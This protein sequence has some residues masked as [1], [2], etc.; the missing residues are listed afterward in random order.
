MTSVKL[1]K[2]AARFTHVLADKLHK[3]FGEKRAAFLWVLMAL[4]E[5]GENLII[6]QSPMNA[7]LTKHPLL[8]SKSLVSTKGA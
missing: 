2:L 3:N 1:H 4:A 6:T 5:N 8:R 7:P